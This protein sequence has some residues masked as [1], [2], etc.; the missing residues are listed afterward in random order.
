MNLSNRRMAESPAQTSLTP[1][2]ARIEYLK[3]P[4]TRIEERLATLPPEENDALWSTRHPRNSGKDRG[5]GLCQPIRGRDSAAGKSASPKRLLSHPSDLRRKHFPKSQLTKL[6]RADLR[7]DALPDSGI[8]DS[9]PQRI[10]SL[11]LTTTSGGTPSADRS[12]ERH[13]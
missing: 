4:P 13:W 10:R 12:A 9:R 1:P 7:C 11:G 2:L 5:P 3:S 8:R 6:I